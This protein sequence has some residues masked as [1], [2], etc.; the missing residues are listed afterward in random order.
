MGAYLARLPEGKAA[1]SEIQPRISA[2][3]KTAMKERDQRT[4]GTLRLVSAAMKD[5]TIA[6]RGDGEERELTDDDVI[7]ILAKMVKQRRESVRAY[8]EGG[9][10]ELAADEEAEIA[11]IERFLPKP[12]TEDEAAAAVDGAIAETGATSLR[13]M[14]KVM[15]ALKAR[16]AGRMDFGAVGPMVKTRLSA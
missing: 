13:D 12:L 10:L 2:A 15:A 4:L 7:G 1:M 11:V 16:H 8:E 14:G 6:M 5:R 3:M 9:R